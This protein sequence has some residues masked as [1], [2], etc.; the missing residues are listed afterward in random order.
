MNVPRDVSIAFAVLAAL[1]LGYT[2]LALARVLAWRVRRPTRAY[3]PAVTILKPLDGLEPQLEENL[4]TFCDQEYPR[5]QIIFCA[6]AAEDPALAIASRLRDAFAS[7]D[8][9]IASGGALAQNPKIANLL[10]AMPLASGEIVVV[11]DSDMRVERDYV[12][13]VVAPFADERVGAATTLYGARSVPST[14]ARLGAMFVNEQFAPSVLVATAVEPLRYCFGATM[15]VRRDALERI[16][17]FEAIGATVADDYALGRLVARS[18]YRVTLAP[19]VPLTLV[20]ER[21]LRDLLA[22]EIRWART[23]RAMRPLGY[24]GSVLAFPMLFG[25]LDVL[26]GF[27]AAAVYGLGAAI[28]L[29]VGL[30]VAAH[31][32]LAIPERANPA[33]VPLREALSVAVWI[34]GL[35]GTHVRWRE[36]RLSL[37]IARPPP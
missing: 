32:A 23:I 36:R 4:R 11:A 16:G 12:A 26:L 30:H 3:E 5:Y 25:V 35:F 18:G 22:R 27:R 8:I 2:S 1:S 34:S 29:R 19:V 15:A 24:V 33:L 21:S 14:V 6:A 37:R 9:A 31:R 13:R 17:G 28:V 20:S 7:K 10:A